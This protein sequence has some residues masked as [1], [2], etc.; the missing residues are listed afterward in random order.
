MIDIATDMLKQCFELV[1]PIILIVIIF[2]FIG[3]FLFNKR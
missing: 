1:I 3:S 2:G